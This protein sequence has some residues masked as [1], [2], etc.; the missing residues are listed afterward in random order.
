MVGGARSLTRTC[1]SRHHRGTAKDEHPHGA[2]LLRTSGQQTAFQ[3]EGVAQAT[4]SGP[5]N[6]R[7]SVYAYAVRRRRAWPGQQQQP[8]KV[9]RP[10]KIEQ[11]HGS[12][13]QRAP[14]RRRQRH[15]HAGATAW[16]TRSRATRW[17][18]SRAGWPRLRIALPWAECSPTPA[19]P[20]LAR[21]ESLPRIRISGMLR[22]IKRMGYG[23]RRWARQ[24]E[25]SA[26]LP[27]AWAPWCR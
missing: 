1:A 17:M 18:P 22:K 19:L 3:A 25:E 8:F 14:P 2:A 12:C 15:Q 26:H 5:L 11:R 10:G 27:R 6:C 4:C 23:A 9:R 20:A 24:K 7:K 13:R 16:S 21:P